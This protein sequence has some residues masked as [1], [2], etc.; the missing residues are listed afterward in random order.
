MSMLLGNALADLFGS[1]ISEFNSSSSLVL[2]LLLI[3]AGACLVLG[4]R[5]RTPK[6]DL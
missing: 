5:H 1:L 3:G 2:A 6:Q 4:A